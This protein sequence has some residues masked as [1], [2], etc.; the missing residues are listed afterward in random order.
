MATVHYPMSSAQQQLWIINQLEPDSTAYNVTEAFELRGRIDPA[1]LSLALDLLIARHENLRT[2]F[3]LEDGEPAQILEAAAPGRMVV[4][5]VSGRPPGE[6]RAYYDAL[7]RDT[8][9]TPYDLAAG[10][11][12]RGTLVRFADSR[13]RLVLGMH[14]IIS[15]AWSAEVFYADLSALYRAVLSGTEPDLP[16]LPIQY[17]DYAVWEHD[18]LIEGRYHRQVRFWRDQL[19][20]A[21]SVLRLP[22]AV[23]RQP[24]MSYETRITEFESPT[25]IADGLRALS[26]K[27]QASLF[28]TTLAIFQVVLAGIS[29]QSDLLVG[30]PVSGRTRKELDGLIGFLVN[31]VPVRLILTD[32]PAFEEVL[33]RTK[34]NV[35]D[36]L[37]NQDLPLD[38]I[39]DIARPARVG[40]MSPLIQA[41]FELVEEDFNPVPSFAGVEVEPLPS[42]AFAFRFDLGM[43]LHSAGPRLSGRLLSRADVL[44]LASADAIVRATL[45]TMVAAVNDPHQRVSAYWAAGGS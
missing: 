10:P 6:A 13:W 8:A 29:G 12:L 4:T 15:D 38:Q 1:A 16:E 43:E 18:G 45:T 5:D 25:G 31:T 17:V 32:D 11:L 41:I 26:R 27:Y 36:A 37:A 28:M 7:I 44:D 24:V 35:L 19:A 23:S 39:I 40:G 42:P 34:N 2:A 30:V 20:G 3:A 33:R 9:R 22:S 21:P 14:H